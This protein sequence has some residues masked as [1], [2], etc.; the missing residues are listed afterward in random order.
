MKP[1]CELSVKQISSRLIGLMHGGSGPAPL[2]ERYAECLETAAE[3]DD[4]SFV[5]MGRDAEA[6]EVAFRHFVAEFPGA[7]A[8]TIPEGELFDMGVYLA[9]VDTELRQSLLKRWAEVIRAKAHQQQHWKTGESM[10]EGLL[11]DE[12]PSRKPI[13]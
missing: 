1:S 13:G 10:H 7:P 9:R 6:F 3:L 12:T 4:L 2:L 5:R 11:F 8:V